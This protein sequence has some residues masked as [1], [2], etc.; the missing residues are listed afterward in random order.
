[1][2][3]IKASII[4]L[5]R[6]GYGYKKNGLSYFS[7]L[8]KVNKF[9]LTSV[10][11]LKIKKIYKKSLEKIKIAKYK[12]YRDIF[13]NNKPDIAIISSSDGTHSEIAQYCIN[14][15]IKGLI[16]EKPL[17]NDLIKFNQ[18]KKKVQ[19]KKITVEVN[20]TRNFIKEF[21]FLKKK[22][23]KIKE[24]KRFQIIFNNGLI[25]NGCHY[26]AL[27]LYIFKSPIKVIY[28]RLNKSKNLRDDFY[29]EITL[30]VKKDFNIDIKI[31]DIK[32]F[33]IDE[34]DVILKKE[35]I[36]VDGD[37]L[38]IS[39]LKRHKKYPNFFKFYPKK[40]LLINYKNA[41]KNLLN[42]YKINYK[43][44]NTKND[45]FYLTNEILN[46]NKIILKKNVNK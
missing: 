45:N 22:I 43:N 38:I 24:I 25:H 8:K 12:D 2:V 14:K 31:L 6:I 26:L 32:N 17:T 1:M 5:G 18:L 44:K 13:N 39:S 19:K 21:F 30:N 41:L 10:C 42:R 15:G 29:G 16:I 3:K 23:E 28:S 27:L 4:G 46:L 35:R 37:K 40:V 7:A 33:S 36:Q 34:I 9:K 11:D 20:Y